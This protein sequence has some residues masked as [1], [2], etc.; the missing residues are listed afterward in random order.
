LKPLLYISLSF[1][2]GS[3]FFGDLKFSAVETCKGGFFWS[4]K[5]EAYVMFPAIAFP[6]LS[7][8]C[9]PLFGDAKA[10]KNKKNS[11]EMIS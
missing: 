11:Y 10:L 9:A 1:K 7:E 8:V 4:F 6:F 2:T 3:F 5:G